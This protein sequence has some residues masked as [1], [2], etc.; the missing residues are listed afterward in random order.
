MQA[1]PMTD[2]PFAVIAVPCLQGNNMLSVLA[3]T[4]S[5]GSLRTLYLPRLI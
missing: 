5:A 4:E 3:L 2:D 1:A